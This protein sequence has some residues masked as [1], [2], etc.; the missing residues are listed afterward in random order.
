MQQDSGS[1]DIYGKHNNTS[2]C[3]QHQGELSLEPSGYYVASITIQ[4]DPGAG[5]TSHVMMFDDCAYRI[6]SRQRDTSRVEPPKAS[7]LGKGGIVGRG[8]W[9]SL[10]D[11]LLIACTVQSSQLQRYATS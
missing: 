2:H 1:D 3:M 4:V 6:G 5:R 11:G 8:G 9:W 7:P 10:C